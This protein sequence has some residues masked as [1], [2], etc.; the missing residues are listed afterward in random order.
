MDAKQKIQQLMND[1]GWTMYR[2]AIE[3][4]LSHT[5]VTNMFRKNNAPTL[6]TLEAICRGLGITMS[7]FFLDNENVVDITTEQK[8]LLRKWS[9][10]SENQKE[11]LLR[12]IDTIPNG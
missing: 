3:S 12:L 9:T 6:S 2:L 10:L 5:T 8:E 1:R 4:G 11:A 7:Q